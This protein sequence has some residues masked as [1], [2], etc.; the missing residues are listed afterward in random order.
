MIRLVMQKIIVWFITIFLLIN[1]S[2]PTLANQNHVNNNNLSQRIITTDWSIAETLLR[3]DA[4]LVGIGDM[5]QYNNWVATPSIPANV[6]DLGLRTQPNMDSL[7]EAHANTLIN[8][9]WFQQ[10]LPPELIE[11][12]YTLYAIDFYTNTG[13]SWQNTVEQTKKLAHFINRQTEANQLIT[14]VESTIETDSIHVAE[15]QHR[16]IAIVQFIDSRHL[17][18]YG[19]NSL[20][21]VVLNKLNLVNAWQQPTNGWGFQQISLLELANLPSDTL[22]I[23]IAPYPTNLQQKLTKNQVWQQLPFANQLNYRLLPAIWAFGALPSMQRFS[24]L[25]TDSLLHP[26]QYSWPRV[27]A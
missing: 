25:L 17:R 23:I 22:L 3:L 11:N 7:I 4:P 26:K 18:I 27:Q 1:L 13:I 6:I 19:D 15:F 5:I 20:Y 12:W 10:I 14:N 8:S 9:S 16:P 24:Q 21:G 2:C